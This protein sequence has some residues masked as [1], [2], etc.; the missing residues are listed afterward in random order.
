MINY[1]QKKSINYSML[2]HILT[3]TEETNQFT[4]MGFA[5]RDLEMELEKILDI[6]PRS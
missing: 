5:K 4:N 1:I 6:A 2:K 3:K